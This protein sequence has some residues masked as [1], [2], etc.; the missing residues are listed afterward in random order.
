MRLIIISVSNF[1][2]IFAAVRGDLFFISPPMR[3]AP[4]IVTALLLLCISRAL[5][6]A[7]PPTPASPT[8]Q[9]F[10]AHEGNFTAIINPSLVSLASGRLLVFVEARLA[11]GGDGDPSRIG[12]K[13][14]DDGGMTWSA[15][16]AL[17]PN[18][19]DPGSTLGNLAAFVVSEEHQHQHQQHQHQQQERVHLVFCVNNTYV[20]KVE[21]DD[22]GE[23]WSS[24]V[25][26]LTSSV[27]LANEGWVA[28]GPANAVVLQQ[29]QQQR[30]RILVPMNTNVGSGTITIDYDL[31]AGAQGRNR[32]CPMASLLV[33]VRGE[34]PSPLP[35]PYH[36]GG[37][38]VDPSVDPG[39]PLPGID[40]CATLTLASLFKLQQR[41]YALI[42]DDAGQT[43]R[44]SATALPLLA[45]ETALAD[46]GGGT[47]LGRSR[48]AEAGWQDGCHHFA[49]SKDGGD[50]WEHL[51]SSSGGGGG[52]GRNSNNNGSSGGGTANTR[53]DHQCIPDPG[54]QT[55]MLALPSNDDNG[56]DR[57]AAVNT[58]FLASPLIEKRCGDHLRGNLTLYRSS[59]AGSTWTVATVVH[60]DCSGYSSMARIASSSSSS[61]SSSSTT[62][63]TTTT[64]TT[65]SSMLGVIWSTAGLPRGG[66]VLFRAIQVD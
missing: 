55:A 8:V 2:N 36:R 50:H 10:S 9:V 30:G 3:E 41:A 1:E 57:G 45:S 19:I 46:L 24:A 65:S 25:A 17:L 6:A 43:W 7:A 52:G 54:V 29:Q 40:P 27:K 20:F 53:G 28:T 31:V 64:T 66:P 16:Q 35:S 48:L 42:S 5:A 26:N 4:T 60:A 22:A 51:N 12:I 56:H 18:G 39:R 11:G 32:Q 63:T 37:G 47:V 44:R 21:S 38:N 23:H 13:H 61:P 14:S 15:M 62:T 49:R 59:D 34:A 33:G 58:V